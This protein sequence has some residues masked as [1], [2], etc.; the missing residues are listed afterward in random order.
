MNLFFRWRVHDIPL[1]HKARSTA[2]RSHWWLSSY[3]VVVLNTLSLVRYSV[4][5]VALQGGHVAKAMC[6]YISSY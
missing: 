2:A 1:S 4:A 5:L 3:G 6:G